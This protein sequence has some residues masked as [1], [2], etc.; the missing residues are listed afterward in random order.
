MSDTGA[1]PYQQIRS[2][3]GLSRWQ[4]AR[5]AAGAAL[6]AYPEDV[7]LM[8]WLAQS[9]I[10]L[11]NPNGALAAA[12][13]MAAVAP[14]EEWAQRLRS[15]ALQELGYRDHAVVAARTAV[16]LAPHLPATHQRLAQ[17][18]ASGKRPFRHRPDLLTEARAAAAESLRLA[19][20]SPEAHFTVG[21]VAQRGGD[22]ETARAAYR[23]TLAL[24]PGHSASLN[25]LTTL[26][27]VSALNAARGYVSALRSDPHS[28]VAQRNLHRLIGLTVFNLY[29]FGAVVLLVACLISAAEGGAG[30]LTVAVAVLFVLGSIA[31]VVAVTRRIP[32]GAWRATTRRFGLPWAA[33]LNAVGLLGVTLLVLAVCL[34]DLGAHVGTVAA[35]PLIVVAVML[36]LRRWRMSRGA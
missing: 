10:G 22:P 1:P 9:E 20:D 18:L 4:Q 21:Y 33:V 2:L 7:R 12:D 29:I 16:R 27:D 36:G 35:R 24:A 5:D 32:R 31:Y 19:P 15:L 17:V 30:P 6:S 13:R 11:K 25:N 14:D 3:I 28:E 23:R 26:G 34:S 8:G